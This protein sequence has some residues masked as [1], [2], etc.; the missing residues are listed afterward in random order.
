MET[1]A[2]DSTRELRRMK[3]E[4]RYGGGPE[5]IA[6]R[7]RRGGG[8]A[9]DRVLRL[10]DPG[11]FVE[12]DVFVQGVVAGYGTVVGRDVYVFSLD[13]ESEGDLLAAECTRKVGKIMDL[14]VKNGAP[15]VGLYDFGSTAGTSPV[16]GGCAGMFTRNALASGVVPQISAILGP[17]EGAA[18]FSA[19]LTDLVVMVRGGSYALLGG[20][21][22]R[23]V[24]PA[25]STLEEVAGARALSEMSGFAHVAVDS[26]DLCLNAVAALLSF[27]PQNNLEETPLMATVDPVDRREPGLDAVALEGTTGAPDM[28]TVAALV[29]DDGEFMELMPGWAKN[30][31]VGFARLGGRAVGVVGNQPTDLDGRLDQDGSV[32]AAR[33]VRL[34]D[35]FNLPVVTFVDTPGFLPGEESGRGRVL[36]EAAKLMYAFCEATVPKVTVITHRA[37]AE[38]FEVMGSKHTG[39]DFNFAWPSAEIV[40]IAPGGGLDRQDTGSPYEAA[41]SGHLDDVIEPSETRLRIIAALEA[42]ASKREDRPAKK[43]G[44]IPL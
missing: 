37:Y 2:D 19:A 7:R 22:A 36:R 29:V 12:L 3:E 10:L 18:V 38:G 1:N 11:S 39:A 14:A 44:N 35:A 9:R 41:V 25:E 20:R 27:L 24:L 23:A 31:V 8:S 15:L 17:C 28:R 33:F 43:H 6:A 21:G 32:K 30:V 40:P 42:C 26:E 13:G 16:L 34:C 4:A 5:R